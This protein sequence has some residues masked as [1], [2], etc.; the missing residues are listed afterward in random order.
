[1]KKENGEN[2]FIIHLKDQNCLIKVLKKI[3]FI[4]K[5]KGDSEDFQIII[6]IGLFDTYRDIIKRTKNLGFGGENMSGGQRQIIN[7]FRAILTKK[8]IILLDEPTSALDEK[9]RIIIY[10]MIKS[11][12]KLNKTIIISTH[13]PE[14][15]KMGNKI[16]QLNKG[17]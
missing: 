13:D 9:N 12:A 15:I 3:Y 5:K 10:K 8:D 1:M 11:M 16:I 6:D 2:K 14:L 17:K 4:L 7:L